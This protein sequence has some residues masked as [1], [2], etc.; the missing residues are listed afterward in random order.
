M[1]PDK[2]VRCHHTGFEKTCF[3]GVAQHGCQKWINVV[4]QNPQTGEPVNQWKCADAWLPVLLIENS[5]C[6]R[7][8]GAAVESFRNEMVRLNGGGPISE[9][10]INLN[11]GRLLHES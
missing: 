10:A 1:L 9:P 11:G 6:Q 8:T 4:G 7:E 2:T 5:R 3:D